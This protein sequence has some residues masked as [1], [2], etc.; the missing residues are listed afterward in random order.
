MIHYLY[1][2]CLYIQAAVDVVQVPVQTKHSAL[3]KC[4]STPKVGAA[5]C[6]NNKKKILEHGGH[7][8]SLVDAVAL[9]PAGFQG[10]LG[11]FRLILYK[12]HKKMQNRSH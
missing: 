9:Y 5:T 7:K 10:K 12:F 6:H 2:P 1:V 8:V 11:C 4:C 3:A